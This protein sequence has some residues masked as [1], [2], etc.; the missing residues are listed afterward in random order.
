MHLVFVD[1]YW[2]EL[3]LDH[4]SVLWLQVTKWRI[5]FE[6]EVLRCF[7]YRLVDLPLNPFFACVRDC[8]LDDLFSFVLRLGHDNL[9]E[10]YL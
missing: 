9:V 4:L 8:Y 2:L 10:A 3:G 7:K 5:N 1:N 6:Y